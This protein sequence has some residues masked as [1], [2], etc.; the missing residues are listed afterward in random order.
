MEHMPYYEM[1]QQLYAMR[2]SISDRSRDLD[3]APEYSHANERAALVALSKLLAQA[4]MAIENL[5]S[6]S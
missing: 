6:M 2:E 3:D 5:E 1:R 4:C